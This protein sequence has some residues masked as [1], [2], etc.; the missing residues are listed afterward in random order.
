MSVMDRDLT[1]FEV[2]SKVTICTG[3]GGSG[4]ILDGARGYMSDVGSEAVGLPKSV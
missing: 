2:I 4:D 3:K 1:H